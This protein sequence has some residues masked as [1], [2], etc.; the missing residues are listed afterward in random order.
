MKSPTLEKRYSKFA[1]KTFQSGTPLLTQKSHGIRVHQAK[2]LEVGSGL[3]GRKIV[4]GAL[5]GLPQ[6]YRTRI[7]QK[8]QQFSTVRQQEPAQERRQG[9]RGLFYHQ[10]KGMEICPAN[11]WGRAGYCPRH[12]L[13]GGRTQQPK[14]L[15]PSGW[16][17]QSALSLL[18][19]IGCTGDGQ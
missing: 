5:H 8:H 7:A 1:R 12:V 14:D 10:R 9:K 18:H 17:H 13:S 4:V 16:D 19:D 3:P 11:V 6:K 15:D 2:P